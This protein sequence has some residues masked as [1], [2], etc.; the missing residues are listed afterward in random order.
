MELSIIIVTWNNE[1][2]IVECLSSLESTIKK[3]EYEVI[4]CDNCSSDNTVEVIKSHYSWVKIVQPGRN[5]GFAGG[6][7]LAVKHAT[8]EYILYLNPDTVMQLETVDGCI[9][10]FYQNSQYGAICC[11]LLNKNKT[12]QPSIYKVPGG[13]G[14]VLEFFNLHNMLYRTLGRMM[15][16]SMEYSHEIE[17]CMGAFVLMRRQDVDVLGG[18]SEQYFMYMEDGDLCYRIKKFLNKKIF[19]LSRYTCIH[20]GG[21]SEKQDLSVSKTKKMIDSYDIFLKLHKNKYRNIYLK[22]YYYMYLLKMYFGKFIWFINRYDKYDKLYRN[23]REASRYIGS[24]LN[25]K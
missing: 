13:I 15:G 8:G 22:F 12:N 5:L 23:C 11:R 6:N 25:K 10:F 20:L 9:S 17:C 2:E 7:N 18:F 3:T 24:L 4:I 21:C 14:M 1:K 16:Y 19:Y